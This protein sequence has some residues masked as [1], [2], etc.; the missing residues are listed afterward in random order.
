LNLR[1]QHQQLR[2][3]IYSKKYLQ[4]TA[5]DLLNPIAFSIAT[6]DFF[7][8]F[9]SF[10][11]NNHTYI[12]DRGYA[13][14]HQLELNTNYYLNKNLKDYK[15]PELNSEIPIMIFSPTIINDGRRMIISSQGMSFLCDNFP[16]YDTK[17][18]PIVENVEFSNLFKKQ[19][20]EQLKFTSALRMSATFPYIMP[21]VTL[22]TTPLINVMDAGMRDNYGKLNTLKYIYTFK[23]WIDNN[24]SGIIILTFRDQPKQK[25]INDNPLQSISENFTSPVGSLYGNLFSIQD[26]NIDDMTQYLSSNI[27]QP[28]DILNFELENVND[29]ISLSWHLTTKEKE[30]VLKSINSEH[31]QKEL[32]RF[33]RLMK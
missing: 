11:Y 10:E 4:N 33:L 3:S 14:E 26:Y 5:K 28:I 2:Y 19:D 25:P 18:K 29:E 6:N 31:N 20:A 24:T 23:Q 9:K 22:P 32:A 16:N 8:R 1:N 12:K 17:S 27:K 13:F 7:I 30:N 15:L 21:S